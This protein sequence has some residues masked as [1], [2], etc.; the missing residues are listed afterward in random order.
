VRES[1]CA[2]SEDR[3]PPGKSQAAIMARGDGLLAAGHDK[4]ART[5]AGARRMARRAVTSCCHTFAHAM[6]PRACAG[7]RI[8]RIGNTPPSIYARSGGRSRCGIMITPRRPTAR[9]TST[10]RL[11]GAPGPGLGGS[12]TG[13]RS[14]ALLYDPLC[15]DNDPRGRGDVPGGPPHADRRSETS[16]ERGQS[17][18][19][20]ILL[21]ARS[22]GAVPVP[23]PTELVAQS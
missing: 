10:A 5:A 6:I 4:W 3:S 15:A 2:F 1:S 18:L 21:V 17:L 19:T 13:P 22:P 23:R 12:S 11:L 20:A 7:L 16:C 9:E 14:A 8:Q